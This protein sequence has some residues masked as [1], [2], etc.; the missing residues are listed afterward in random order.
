MI[1]FCI[2]RKAAILLSVLWLQEE[3]IGLW[4]YVIE[5]TRLFIQDWMISVEFVRDRYTNL[6]PP[7]ETT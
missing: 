2:E 3:Y 5:R 7:I 6:V 1:V 4:S